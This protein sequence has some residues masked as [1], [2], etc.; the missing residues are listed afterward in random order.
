MVQIAP[1]PVLMEA[2][3]YTNPHTGNE[4]GLH[5]AWCSPSFSHISD[6]MKL[7]S[8]KNKPINLKQ[9]KYNI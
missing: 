7:K 5:H 9:S 2:T 1:A 4:K 3:S 8:L 6:I